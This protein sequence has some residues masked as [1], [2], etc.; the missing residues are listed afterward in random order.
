M[1]ADQPELMARETMGVMTDTHA[2]AFGRKIM[3]AFRARELV[4]KPLGQVAHIFL[5]I[6][7]SGG[8]MS[9]FA[10]VSAYY[11]RG[12]VVARPRRGSSCLP[13]PLPPAAAALRQHP[14]FVRG[15]LERLERN[16]AVEQPRQRVAQRRQK[17]R[18]FRLRRRAAPA[19]PL[20]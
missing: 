12:S 4:G 17:R 18:D 19:P 20:W 3:R 13:L 16:G 6:D 2:R 7:P 15:V 8:G 5:A 10:V 9:H 14:G 11:H 1:M